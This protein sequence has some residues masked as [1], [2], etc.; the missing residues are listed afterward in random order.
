MMSEETQ[1]CLFKDN[2][3]GNEDVNNIL[4]LA[5]NLVKAVEK[6]VK[7]NENLKEDLSETDHHLDEALDELCLMQYD[8]DNLIEEN[9]DL[10]NTEKMLRSQIDDMCK[11]V[12]N[13]R[14]KMHLDITRDDEEAEGTYYPRTFQEGMREID[15]LYEGLIKSIDKQNDAYDLKCDDF[16]RIDKENDILKEKLK[17]FYYLTQEI[18]TLASINDV[19]IKPVK[20]LIGVE[21]Y[22]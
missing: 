12:E 7:D 13:F 19:W 17:N 15:H 22:D 5:M 2:S 20:E 9:L 21:V 3:K 16:I 6:L 18:E 10:K 14:K 4:G 11:Q 8:K 1:E